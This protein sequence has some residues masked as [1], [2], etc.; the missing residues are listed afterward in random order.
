LGELGYAHV[1]PD[2]SWVLSVMAEGICNVLAMFLSGVISQS[3]LRFWP[4]LFVLSG[5]ATLFAL[6]PKRAAESIRGSRGGERHGG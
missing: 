3:V 2:N 4:L 6:N 5:C 1:A